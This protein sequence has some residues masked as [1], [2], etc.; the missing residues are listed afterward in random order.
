MC[1]L[2]QANCCLQSL[3]HMAFT[4]PLIYV[5]AWLGAKHQGM[6]P[7]QTCPLVLKQLKVW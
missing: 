1:F 2:P 4:V 7:N 5:C 3:E 6:E